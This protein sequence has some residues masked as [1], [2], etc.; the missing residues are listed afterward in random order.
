MLTDFGW[1]PMAHPRRPPEVE[2][3][4]DRLPTNSAYLPLGV[5]S[6]EDRTACSPQ[7]NRDIRHTV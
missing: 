7:G 3:I 2:S 4:R 6:T 5:N 1:L